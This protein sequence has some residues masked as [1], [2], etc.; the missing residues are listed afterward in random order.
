VGLFFS[1]PLISGFFS[2]IFPYQSEG[3]PLEDRKQ[4]MESIQVA[5]QVIGGLFLALGVY[6][7]HK[8]L[9][10][11]EKQVGIAEKN[12]YTERFNKSIEQLGS[13]K[14]SVI[15]GGVFTLDALA[16][17][18]PEDFH[19][20]VYN[21]LCAFI[22]DHATHQQSAIKTDSEDGYPD[23]HEED[24][25]SW[26]YLTKTPVSYPDDDL[27]GKKDKP[28]SVVIETVLNLI[29]NRVTS[30]DRDF[31]IDLRYANLRN[32]NL[33][34]TNLANAKL[35]GVNLRGANLEETKLA[36]AE[37]NFAILINAY[38]QNSDLTDVQLTSSSLQ[39]VNLGGSILEKANISDS[40]LANA[41]LRKANLLK[42]NFSGSN[43]DTEFVDRDQLKQCL[44]LFGA[45][46]IRDKDRE[47]LVKHNPNMFEGPIT[48]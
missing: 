4:L 30:N 45:S 42:T 22:R 1:W 3:M 6:F 25:D 8:R 16:R 28:V 12:H 27:L 33:R 21:L 31:L 38:M 43:L 10:A 32:A 24:P 2:V 7:T 34:G 20:T 23:L 39:N 14:S 41:F 46:G 29:T 37:V 36:G 44:S 48:I 47:F 9:V 15:L 40:N 17:N 13:D 35:T 5:T 26:E 11:L 18:H 19:D